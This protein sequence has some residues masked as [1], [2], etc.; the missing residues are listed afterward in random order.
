MQLNFQNRVEH[1]A[2]AEHECRRRQ[3]CL[4]PAKGRGR[5]SCKQQNRNRSTSRASTATHGD[6][7]LASV[8]SGE[9]LAK[10]ELG[11]ALNIKEFAVLA[12]VSY[13]M[14]R[15]WFRLP[16]FPLFEGVVFWKD[17][18]RWREQRAG[19]SGSNVGG[20]AEPAESHP[21]P[22]ETNWSP[23][24]AKILSSFA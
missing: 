20:R 10:R 11:Q 23:Q 14:A 3:P 6:K 8:D 17:F 9:A 7:Q 15:Q 4:L 16:G 13:S 19:L 12:G 1:E 2:G 24:A 22:L 5:R 21:E 18:E